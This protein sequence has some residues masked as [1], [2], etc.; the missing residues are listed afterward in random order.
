MSQLL[1]KIASDGR[2]MSVTMTT[3]TKSE[4][5]LMILVTEVPAEPS[6]TYIP[7][8]W[9]IFSSSHLH[10]PAL[11]RGWNTCD[12]LQVRINTRI[13]LGSLVENQTP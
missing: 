8:L 4:L 10:D 11:T 13:R 9:N 5:G 12:N 7:K 1:G 2:I 3:L 6:V